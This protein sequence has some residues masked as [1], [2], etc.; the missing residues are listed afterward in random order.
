MQL[1]LHQFAGFRA[2]GIPMKSRKIGESAI[3]GGFHVRKSMPSPP[4]ING[5][6]L[7]ELSRLHREVILSLEAETATGR[8]RCHRSLFEDPMCASSCTNRDMPLPL[9]DKIDAFA[10][11]ARPARGFR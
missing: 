9:A 8:V 1:V 3:L 6:R 2:L 11:F 10:P 7:C 4:Q 5:L